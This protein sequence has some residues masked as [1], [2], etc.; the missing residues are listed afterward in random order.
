MKLVQ[1]AQ[2]AVDLDRAAEFYSKL[3]GQKPSGRFDPPGLLFFDLEG[4]RLLL[5]TGAPS[6]TL[7]LNVQD[8]KS[9]IEHL[10]VEGVPIEGEPHVIFEHSDDSLGPKGT[11]E[12]QAFIRD[13]EGNLIALVEHVLSV[14]LP[15][16]E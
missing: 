15:G 11:Q 13:S 4:T 7:Y 2:K 16:S 9:L 6:A 14:P 1:I 8:L 10:R 3:L 12:W 5:G